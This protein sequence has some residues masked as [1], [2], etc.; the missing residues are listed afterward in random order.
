[1][2]ADKYLFCAIMDF[3][4]PLFCLSLNWAPAPARMHAY[5]LRTEMTRYAAPAV[6]EPQHDV[7]VLLY[8][9]I[10]FTMKTKRK[11]K[12]TTIF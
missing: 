5:G 4:F 12:F 2:Q 11:K 9:S 10:Y 7:L 1:M 6:A 8:R 3:F